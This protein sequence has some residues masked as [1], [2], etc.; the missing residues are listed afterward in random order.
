VQGKRLDW[1]S[2]L[3]LDLLY[4]ITLQFVVIA[5]YTVYSRPLFPLRLRARDPLCV[6]VVVCFPLCVLPSS[7][8]SGQ[9]EGL[10]RWTGREGGQQHPCSQCSTRPAH[11]L[12]QRCEALSVK[13]SQFQ[14]IAIKF[15]PPRPA[16]RLPK[17][18]R[19]GQS[20]RMDRSPRGLQAFA[21]DCLS[22]L[23]TPAE[24]IA[25][26]RITNAEW[27][28]S[29]RRMD[30]RRANAGPGLFYQ[31]TVGLGAGAARRRAARRA[32]TARHSSASA[33]DAVA[34]GGGAAEFATRWSHPSL[35]CA[36]LVERAADSAGEARRRG[37][38]ALLLS[39]LRLTDCRETND[40]AVLCADAVASGA[41]L[42]AL[43]RALL[44]LS[45]GRFGVTPSLPAALDLA[46]ARAGWFQVKDQQVTHIHTATEKKK[47]ITHTHDKNNTPNPQTNTPPQTLNNARR[48]RDDGACHFPRPEPDTNR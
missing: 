5:L 9:E 10:P 15:P 33:D 39:S 48:W 32:A 31:Q 25:L 41:A 3:E 12:K 22:R 30:A 34:A 29:L 45:N 35:R 28:A 18:G 20:V 44:L 47:T 21:F 14:N 6:V 43:W 24:R 16:G 37:A 8:C 13:G 46:G 42:R 2:T 17:A 26:L 36:R 27:V 7:V 38:E 11:L 40:T 4:P 1:R 23:S 19:A